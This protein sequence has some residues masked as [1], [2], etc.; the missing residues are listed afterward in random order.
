MFNIKTLIITS[1]FT[2]ATQLLWLNDVDEMYVGCVLTMTTDKR[3]GILGRYS[4]N[5]HTP[6]HD[7]KRSMRS[8]RL[9]DILRKLIP[10]APKFSMRSSRPG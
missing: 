8:P 6:V 1:I 5:L 3:D 2:S 9:G 4:D 10:K 7:T